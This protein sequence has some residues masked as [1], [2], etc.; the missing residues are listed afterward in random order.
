VIEQTSRLSTHNW[1]KA[2]KIRSPLLPIA[3]AVS[4]CLLMLYSDDLVAYR[5]AKAGVYRM[6]ARVVDVDTAVP[7]FIEQS[8]ARPTSL[9]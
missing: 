2:V 9:Q 6:L 3:T 8:T 4:C 7:K 1:L 5:L